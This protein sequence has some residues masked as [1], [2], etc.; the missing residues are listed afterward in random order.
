MNYEDYKALL[1]GRQESY[2]QLV[3]LAEDV[4]FSLTDPE[5]RS[6]LEPLQI[7]V[8]PLASAQG[9]TLHYLDRFYDF[10]FE[11]LFESPRHCTLTTTIR[12]AKDGVPTVFNKV[13]LDVRG[14]VFSDLDSK[15]PAGYI[16]N[17]TGALAFVF[18]QLADATEIEVA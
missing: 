11:P 6:E 16:A 13:F 18:E 2:H 14:N 12:H 4:T 8:K 9:F 7:E 1:L 17:S 15:E 10:L 3:A 5:A